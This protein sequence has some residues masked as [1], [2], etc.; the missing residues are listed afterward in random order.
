MVLF[1]VQSFF[2][3]PR[4]LLIRMNVLLHDLDHVPFSHISQQIQSIFQGVHYSCFCID[5]NLTALQREEVD[6]LIA[7]S[8]S[9]SEFFFDVHFHDQWRSFPLEEDLFAE[10]MIELLSQS[11]RVADFHHPIHV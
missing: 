9:R 1:S 2:A 8:I 7:E 3:I 5:S 4:S 11:V 10:Q 6:E